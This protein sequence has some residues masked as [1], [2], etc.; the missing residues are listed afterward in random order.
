MRIYPTSDEALKNYYGD[1]IVV[2]VDGGFAVMKITD[3]IVW[4]KQV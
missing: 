3:Y 2:E 1:E 4:E